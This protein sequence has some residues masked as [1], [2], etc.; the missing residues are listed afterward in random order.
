MAQS[1]KEMLLAFYPMAQ[2]VLDPGGSGC[3]TIVIGIPRPDIST[4][5]LRRY[6]ALSGFFMPNTDHEVLW[7]DAFDRFVQRIQLLLDWEPRGD[8]G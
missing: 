4:P 8:L 6:D 7:E 2:I 1:K 3:D 5:E